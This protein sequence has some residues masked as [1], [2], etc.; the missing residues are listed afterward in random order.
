MNT[1]KG[2]SIGTSGDS[3]NQSFSWSTPTWVCPQHTTRQHVCFCQNSEQALIEQPQKVQCSRTRRPGEDVPVSAK[4]AY[5]TQGKVN[6][7]AIISG[8]FI[9]WFC[10]SLIPYS[11]QFIYLHAR[12]FYIFLWRTYIS[13]TIPR[14]LC[15]N[16]SDVS[17]L[18]PLQ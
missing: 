12:R 16:L 8:P 7:L 17:S 18:R 1:S 5:W 10:Q 13:N 14:N 2:L 4:G 9:C 11:L 3:N 6:P 15:C